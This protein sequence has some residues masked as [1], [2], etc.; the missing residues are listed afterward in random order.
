VLVKKLMQYRDN[1]QLIGF[2]K[3]KNGEGLL[4]G[5]VLEVNRK[6]VRFTL[7]N[8]DGTADE[9]ATLRVDELSRLEEDPAYAKRLQLFEQ[10]ANPIEKKVGKTT[11]ARTMIARRL[12]A[13]RK[14]GESVT[15]KLRHD[16]ARNSRILLCAG[17]YIE[18]EEF[19]DDPLAVITS[20]IVHVGQVESLRWRSTNELAVTRVWRKFAQ[21]KNFTKGP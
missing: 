21:E 11:R 14:T 2:C 5:R 4:F 18:F 13:A 3:W 9:E 10:Y 19:G 16:P 8:P 12:R 20:R 15:L 17:D 1:N 6:Q 7:L